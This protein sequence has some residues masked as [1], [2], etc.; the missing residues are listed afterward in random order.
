MS[1]SVIDAQDDWLAIFVDG[2][3]EIDVTDCIQE[4][5]SLSEI[6]IVQ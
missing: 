5:L 1:L 6:I 4:V 3:D 2:E